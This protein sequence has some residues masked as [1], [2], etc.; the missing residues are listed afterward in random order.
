MAEIEK[1]RAW[2]RTMRWLRGA[3][4]LLISAVLGALA[5]Y[6][7]SLADAWARNRAGADISGLWRSVSCSRDTSTQ[8]RYVIDA[9][10]IDVT[11]L[12]GI[13]LRNAQR[14]IYNYAGTGRILDRRYFVGEWRSLHPGATARGSFEFIIAPQGDYLAGTF[15]GN[16]EQGNYVMCWLLGRDA[17]SLERARGFMARQQ[18]VPAQAPFIAAD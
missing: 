13:T 4:V 5:S 7:L 6:A 1:T 17:A 9:V 12:G 15:T 14:D 3:S 18:A 10:H 2:S 16:D 11:Y 8:G